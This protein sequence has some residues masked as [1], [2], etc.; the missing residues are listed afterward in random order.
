MNDDDGAAWVEQTA[1][2][3]GRTLADPTVRAELLALLDGTDDQRRQQRRLD[4]ARAS[5]AGL[6][7]RYPLLEGDEHGP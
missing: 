3:L 2:E 4:A 1:A 6:E 5:L 7:L